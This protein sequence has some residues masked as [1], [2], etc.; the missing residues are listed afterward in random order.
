MANR[1]DPPHDRVVLT[2]AEVRIIAQLERSI[3][4]LE[5]AE[6][7]ARAAAVRAMRMSSRTSTPADRSRPAA[8]VPP[9]K[10]TPKTTTTGSSRA[11]AVWAGLVRCASWL[12]VPLGLGLVVV[13]IASS[14]IVVLLGAVFTGLGLAAAV[15]RLWP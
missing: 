11:L 12:L 7:E 1:V 5:Q 2:L 9:A 13:G 6:T 15:S 8:A 3:A 10:A 4:E 14:T